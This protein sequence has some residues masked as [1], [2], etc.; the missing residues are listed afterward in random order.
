[1]STLPR[2]ESDETAQESWTERRL[3]DVWSEHYDGS[4]L[5]TTEPG[6]MVSRLSSLAWDQTALELGVGTGRV[7]LPLARTGVTVDGIEFS[8]PMAKKLQAKVQDLPVVV[9][10]GDMAD[11]HDM[12]HSYSLVYA[13]HS[14]LH[15]LQT[16]HDQVRCL[17]NAADALKAGG[18]LV[19]ESVHPQV[20]AG[21]LRGK[22]IKIRNL[23]D[24]ELALSATVVDTAQ[25]TVRF[26]E[27]SF[28]DNGTRMLPCHIRWIWPSEL[29]LMAS[30][31]GLKRISRDA[32]WHGG[33]VTPESTQYVCVYQKE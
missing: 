33:A 16:Q 4:F 27:I 5:G 12:G 24:S 25:Q 14:A 29:D 21:P 23:T 28:G 20:F 6:E 8:G 3:W 1:M 26:Q 30:M 11:R 32:D 2:N 7:A 22:N 31:A 10:N 18:H 17:M 9:I 15:L 19:V 13:V